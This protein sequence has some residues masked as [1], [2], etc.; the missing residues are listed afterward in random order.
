M[1]G[2]RKKTKLELE[3]LTDIHMLF[4][5]KKGIKGR[6]CHARHQYAATNNK[7]MKDYDKNKDLSYLICWDVNNLCGWAMTQNLP[8]GGFERVKNTSH[9]NEDFMK[10]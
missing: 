10:K 9:S 5:I 2:C 8:V 6:I 1:A 3:S 4:M 7:Y